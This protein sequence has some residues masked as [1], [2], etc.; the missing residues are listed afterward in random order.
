M[1]VIP[2][3]EI[4][5]AYVVMDEITVTE[6]SIVSSVPPPLCINQWHG[7]TLV[8]LSPEVSFTCFY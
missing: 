2:L 7:S 3:Q 6:S 8:Q 4:S 1:K 5:G